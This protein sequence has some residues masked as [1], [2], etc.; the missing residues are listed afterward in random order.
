MIEVEKFKKDEL[1]MDVILKTRKLKKIS[2][3]ILIL[4]IVSFFALFITGCKSQQEASA[5]SR[6]YYSFTDSLGNQIHLEENL[7][8]LFLLLVLMLKPGFWQAGNLLA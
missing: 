3:I 2:G 1:S 7:K 4:V 6:Y 5:S 8:G